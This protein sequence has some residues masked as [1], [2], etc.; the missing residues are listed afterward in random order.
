MEL[1]VSIKKIPITKLQ[2]GM[3]LVGIDVSWM[4]SPFYKHCFMIS[5]DDEILELKKLG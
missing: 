2:Q 4:K 1:N 3:Y 5:S